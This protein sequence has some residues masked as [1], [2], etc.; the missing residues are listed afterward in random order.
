MGNRAV[1]ETKSRDIGVYLHWNGGRD[2]V[3][4][5]LLYCKLRGFRSPEYDSY[6]WAR[7]CQVI[8]NFFGGGLSLG[9]DIPSRLDEDNG[10]HGVYIIENWN[11]VNRLYTRDRVE[12]NVHQLDEMLKAINDSQ[13][14]SER[15][16]DVFLDP[17]VDDKIDP[18]DLVI[19]DQVLYSSCGESL[20]GGAVNAAPHRNHYGTVMV[21]VEGSYGGEVAAHCIIRT[22]RY[23]TASET[24]AD[25]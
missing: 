10:D 21:P 19:G 9:I 4:A 20:A 1:I 18:M 11:I 23:D 2:S 24:A 5:F 22:A 25:D 15:L 17:E 6:G 13:P 12:Q 14:E 3:A 8:G 7:L 16:P